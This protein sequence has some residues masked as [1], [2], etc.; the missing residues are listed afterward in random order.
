MSLPS[1]TRYLLASKV[2]EGRDISGALKAFQTAIKNAN[3]ALPETV[4]TDAHKS[5]SIGMKWAFDSVGAK[6]KHV[7]NCGV[8]KGG[9]QTNNRIERLN[10]TMRERVKVTRGW[11]SYQTPIAEGPRIAYNF[12]KPHQALG[13]RTPAEAAGLKPKGWKEL[14]EL[15]VQNKHPI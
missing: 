11:K 7:K 13:G 10:G 8:N 9:H 6:P 15:A 2:S 14:M 4:M 5:Y 12:V 3:G 1:E